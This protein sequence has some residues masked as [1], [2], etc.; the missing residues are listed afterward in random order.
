MATNIKF[1]LNHNPEKPTLI[2]VKKGGDKLGFLQVTEERA[3][4][5]LTDAP[6]LSFAMNKYLDG[7]LNYLWD[8]VRD[9]RLVWWK[10]ENTLF[11]LTVQVN[12]A[13]D[14]V[15]S[16]D[17]TGLAQAEL[18]QINVYGTH[19][20]NEDD[21]NWEGLTSNDEKEVASSV[22]YKPDNTKLSILHR[23]IEKAPHYS[24][25]HVDETIA[26][27][28]RTFD[29]DGES[30]L[31]V[32]DD[33]EK[34]IGCLITVKVEYN[35]NGELARNI[36]VYDLQDYCNDCH[37]R[38]DNLSGVCPKC[39]STNITKGYG[40]DTTIFITAD[41]LGE[42]IGYSSNADQVKNCFRLEAGDDDM[43]AAV[44]NCNPNGTDYIW[45]LSSIMRED[46]SDALRNR[47][48]SYDTLYNQYQTTQSISLNSS[49][50]NAYNTVINKYKI[51]NSDLKT[52]TNPV[53]GYP[54]LMEAYYDVL[55]AGFFIEES[56]MPTVEHATETAS[57]QAGLLTVAN[58]SPVG[59]NIQL[60]SVT[61]DT[62]NS[63]VL[64]M[65][66]AICNSTKFKITVNSG[67]YNA[68]THK[69]TGNF[70]IVNYSDEEDTATSSSIT[71]TI[72]D[73]YVTFIKRKIDKV[74]NKEK[75]EDFSVTGL[76]S[77][78]TSLAT[79][80]N[81]I[82]Q[83]GLTPLKSIYDCGM[84][85]CNILV[86]QGV[87][88]NGQ[89]HGSG[90]SDPY[91]QI[92]IPYKNKVD[93]VAQ[94]IE[95]RREDLDKVIGKRD[96]N[97]NITSDG[98]QTVIEKARKNIQDN[99]DLE[100]YLGSTL[101][102]EFCSFRRDDEY[103]NNNYI[104]DGLNNAEMF[105]NALKFVETASNE[106]YKSA[107]L[108]HS[109]TSTLRN[110]LYNEKF[111]PLL[112]YFEVGNW[113]RIKVDDNIF[114][115]RL[116]EYD[117]DFDS[118]DNISVK[119]SDVTKI[120]DGISDV[121]DILNK[122][123]SMASSYNSV[124]R[125]AEKG[126]LTNKIVDTWFEDGLSA[127]NTR[128]IGGADNQT[129]TWDDKG[130][131]FRRYDSVTDSYDPTQIKIINSTLAVTDDNWQTVKTA[132]G[133]FYY[134]DPADGNTKMG[135]GING[136]VV[137][138][139]LI[140]GQQL[141]IYNSGNTLKFDRNGLSVENS[142]N[143]VLIDPSD[144]QLFKVQKKNGNNWNNVIWM[145]NSGNAN[146]NGVIT[147][148]SGSIGG[149]TINSTQLLY[150]DAVTPG[151]AS[152]QYQVYVRAGTGTTHAFG[153]QHRAYDGTSYEATWTND[154]VVRHDGYMY[155]NNAHIK[156]EVTAT[157]GK[158]GEFTLSNGTLSHTSGD[159]TITLRNV[160]TGHPEYGVFYITDSS[161]TD[162]NPFRING[163]GSIKA[164]KGTIGGWA[165]TATSLKGEH[166]NK[167]T[168][169]QI[170]SS[171]TWAIAVGYDTTTPA[172]GWSTAPFRVNHSGQMWATDAHITG[173]ITG[174]A[175]EFTQSFKTNIEY[176]PKQE[177]GT[178]LP[179]RIGFLEVIG[180]KLG[181]GNN[182][183]HM[184]VNLKS[185]GSRR[186]YVY[187][188][189]WID[190]YSYGSMA[191]Q[192]S[193]SIDLTVGSGSR[194]YL[195]GTTDV[196]GSVLASSAFGSGGKTAWN[197][198]ENS[199]TWITSNGAI[200][201]TQDGTHGGTI[202]FH[203]NFSANA[204][205]SLVETASGHVKLTGELE[206]SEEITSKTYNGYSRIPVGSQSDDG[207]RVGMIRYTS[208]NG[209]GIACQNGT[210][211]SSYAWRNF[212]VSSSD[213]RLKKN[214]E[215]CEVDDALSVINQ[216]QMHSFDWLH[217]EEHQRI[218]FIADELEQIDPKLSMGGGT[219]RDGTINYKS[220]DTFYLLGYL[221]KGI[222]ELSEKVSILERDN[223]SLRR[224][225]KKLAK[226]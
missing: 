93:A 41:E 194:I 44:R 33:I 157:S 188:S 114:K 48:S 173:T 131:L 161:A 207:Q 209:G 99:L 195:Q 162:Q 169:F 115:L 160:Q 25:V 222:Q 81:L 146:F 70:N 191:I 172:S 21:P 19:I 143:R 109:I 46:M 52:I 147:A 63:N 197:D 58:I 140:L 15:K 77:L 100:T 97:G 14:T 101:W 185:G 113:L 225:V 135:Y 219:E 7:E 156:G 106:L 35:S 59:V 38:T 90:T 39:G 64:D 49:I 60:S 80:K 85:A 165:I 94:E 50:V 2:L 45:H 18:S 108:Q 184:G 79:F 10:E 205:S 104:S 83:Y 124:K 65:A 110:L 125:Q 69:W 5:S 89:S 111:E 51:Y 217:T 199:G 164:T 123:S 53:I 40:E 68:S 118:F 154:F 223:N 47:L 27:V 96:D 26:N 127:T 167:G 175:G 37:T 62:A 6:E 24:I 176:T 8:E 168:G 17:C 204:T 54:A 117:I 193:G 214:V 13:D 91:T 202:G 206:V 75:P 220:V 218:G 170:P 12:E 183:I 4:K 182:G 129:Q 61:T 148:T 201:M 56:M 139:K 121:Q 142:T 55:D 149:W 57:Q 23:V 31:D 86:E 159:Y 103:S 196:T 76:Y 87:A 151:T 198:T 158:I 138:G 200:H 43:T 152:T 88:N 181:L 221:T 107:E 92:Y 213:I 210:A 28:Q 180:G 119:F 130:M 145:D 192:S 137:I 174:S 71:V 120:K 95:I 144:S 179:A 30:I 3:T 226:E 190:I 16:V 42:K 153:V 29:F 134:V 36:Y 84:K 82:K 166:S 11:E 203:Y 34:E 72:T 112:D 102:K 186:A 187:I 136:E 141:G 1:D 128:I 73:D 105:D 20:N 66:K 216:I 74:L 78:D 22:L 178:D 189:D 155:A 212:S 150:Q 177:D 98:M 9:F 133:Q 132:V 122:S 126:N 116:L 67:S 215:D 163:D 224:E 211:G 171:G 208:S 32:F